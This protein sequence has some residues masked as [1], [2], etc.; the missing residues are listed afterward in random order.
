MRTLLVIVSM[1][2][3]AGGCGSN[4]TPQPGV[5]GGS[6]SCLPNLDGR[7][8]V[9]ELPVAFDQVAEYFVDNNATV[10]LAGGVDGEGVRVW[11]FADSADSATRQA[12]SAE[13]VTDKWYAGQFP[14]AQWANS[15]LAGAIDSVF[16]LDDSG[17]WLL[18]QA[19]R[20]PD[21]PSG[22]TLIVYQ[23]P[24][25]V[26]RLPLER[27]MEWTEVGEVVDGEINGLPY[28]ATDTYV[29]RVSDSGR[30]ELPLVKFSP[31]FKVETAVDVV[32][33]LGGVTVSRRQTSFFFECFGELVRATSRDDE[34]QADFSTAA[35]L[36]RFAL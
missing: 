15:D 27:G 29:I 12:L 31:A 24:V 36:R 17:L 5:D 34:S 14:G 3:M 4:K 18:G 21:P 23:T 9:S 35:E 30:V 6:L 26:L 7:I 33:A 20:Q 28:R 1:V 16:R 13:S 22:R 32:P 10:N 8:D 25:A 11:S 2:V 19:S